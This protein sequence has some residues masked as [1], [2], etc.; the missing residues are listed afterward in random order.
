[1]FQLQAVSVLHTRDSH[2]IILN[3]KSGW[4][5]VYSGDC[6]P[7][8]NLIKEGDQQKNSPYSCS[9][10]NLSLCELMANDLHQHRVE[11]ILLFPAIMSRN[12]QWNRFHN[13][14]QITEFSL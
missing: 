3:H 1:M 6:V 2:G 11:R 5:L 14:K 8:H 13:N 12:I 10:Q 7:S 4:K 9:Q